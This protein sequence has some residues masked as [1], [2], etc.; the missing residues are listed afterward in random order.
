MLPCVNVT[1]NDLCVMTTYIVTVGFGV[2]ENGT[3]DCSNITD[4]QSEYLLPNIT[5]EFCVNT[6]AVKLPNDNE[7]YCVTT[8]LQESCEF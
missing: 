7:E 2:R 5:K 4:Y 8:T 3:N 6:T 1:V